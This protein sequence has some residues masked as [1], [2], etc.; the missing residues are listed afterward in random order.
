[1]SSFTYL[2]SIVKSESCKVTTRWRR[3]QNYSLYAIS[4]IRH[5]LFVVT[6]ILKENQSLCHFSYDRQFHCSRRIRHIAGPGLLHNSAGEEGHRLENR[7]WIS[8]WKSC[9]HAGRFGVGTSGISLSLSSDVQRHNE[10]V[11]Q[12]MSICRLCRKTRKNWATGRPTIHRISTAN[13]K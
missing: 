8:V 6:T 11:A 5:I 10:E 1:M 7:I 12:S 2:R 13:E 9:R 4:S 3:R